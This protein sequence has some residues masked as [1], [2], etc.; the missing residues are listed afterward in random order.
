M[1]KD[2]DKVEQE[3]DILSVEGEDEANVSA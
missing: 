1:E 2:I 3:A